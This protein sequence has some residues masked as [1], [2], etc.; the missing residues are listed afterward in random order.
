MGDIQA[1][2]QILKMVVAGLVTVALVPV[3]PALSADQ[4]TVT[5]FGGAF[6]TALRNAYFEPFSKEVGIKITE[7][8]YSG[9]I[10]KV[11]AMVDTKNVGWDVVD[12]TGGWSDEMCNQGIIEKI[13]WKK[14]DLDRSK[15]LGAERYE[16]GVPSIISATVVA[17]DKDKLPN[18]PKT[19]ADLFDTQ[20]F[21]GKRGLNKSP[22]VTLEWALIADGV[23]MNDVYKVLRTPEGV[24]RAFKKLD[25]IKKDIVWWQSGAQPVQLLADGQVTMT[26]AWNGRIY[27]AVKNSGKHFEILWDA[28]SWGPNVWT[29][30]KGTP[31]REEAYKFIAYASSP[32]TQANITRYIPYSPTNKDA[33]AFIDP[34][35]LPHLPAAPEHVANALVIDRTFRV[36]K[37]AELRERF[38]NWLAK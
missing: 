19:I 16:C 11:R 26:A 6:Q 30:P 8:E 35:I 29:I 22:D 17:Y 12:T 5:S 38:T 24:D 13:D 18:G 10:S 1:M 20:R 36:E 3:G 2:S 25:T 23:P 34:Q 32:R 37:S 31:R 15:F 28:A 33:M 14:L 4:L 9:E 27:D 7:D 21:P